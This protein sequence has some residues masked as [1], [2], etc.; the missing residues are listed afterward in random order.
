MEDI[1]NFLDSSEAKSIILSE[2]NNV[3]IYNNFID[4]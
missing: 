3:Y 1:N 2:A 4:C